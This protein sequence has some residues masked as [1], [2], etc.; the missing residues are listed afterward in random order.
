MP[1]AD[2]HGSGLAPKGTPRTSDSA[3]RSSSGSPLAVKDRNMAQSVRTRS[4][5]VKPLGGAVVDEEIGIAGDCF[6]RPAGEEHEVTDVAVA[7]GLVGG[8]VGEPFASGGGPVMGG[9]VDEELDDPPRLRPRGRRQASRRS[10]APPS[11]T[12]IVGSPRMPM[13]IGRPVGRPEECS[14]AVEAARTAR[15]R[16][17]VG[18]RF[19]EVE[20]GLDVASVSLVTC[21]GS[22]GSSW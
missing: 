13:V 19:G 14:P 3:V 4:A 21:A 18:R 2:V 20:E 15:R 8:D 12:A 17:G 6:E 5:R 11:P 9:E 22:T 16:V 10:W 7:Q 1:A